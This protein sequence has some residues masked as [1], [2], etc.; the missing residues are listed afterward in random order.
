M[1]HLFLY[2]VQ[3]DLILQGL[4]LA[5]RELI[6]PI[7][8]QITHRGADSNQEVDGGLIRLLVKVLNCVP[9]FSEGEGTTV[10]FS[11]HLKEGRQILGFT[12]VKAKDPIK[13]IRGIYSQR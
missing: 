11:Q 1:S 9:L 12:M 4:K 8:G 5:L 3:R 2:S 6:L 7:L 10:M 13:H